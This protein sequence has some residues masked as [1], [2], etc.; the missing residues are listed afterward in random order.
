VREKEGL[1][2]STYTQFSTSSIDQ[3]GVFRVSAI[4]APQNRAR[5]KQAIAEEL[6]RAVRE[7]FTAAEVEVGKKAVLEARRL[8]RT[9]DRTLNARIANYMY[10]GRTFDWDIELESKITALTPDEV[11]NALRR[12][13]DLGKLA[14]VFA[15][16]FKKN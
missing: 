1:S 16:D 3:Y 2:Y 5:V 10:L 13:I 7:G 6:A 9:Q 15:G 12:H 11:G 8:Q 14:E 4:F